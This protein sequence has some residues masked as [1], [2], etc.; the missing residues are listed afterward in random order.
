MT[1]DVHDVFVSYNSKDSVTAKKLSESLKR[2][3]IKVWTDQ[4]LIPG[5]PFIEGI[6]Q[7]ITNTKSAIVLIGDS[8]F[9]P[10][11]RPEISGLLI[12]FVET[13]LPL[14][15]VFLPNS[16]AKPGDL[17]VFLRG[18]STVDFRNGFQQAEF[19]RLVWAVTGEKPASSSAAVF[20]DIRVGHS[21][22][23]NLT[24]SVLIPLAFGVLGALL[25]LAYLFTAQS[26]GL[27]FT[28]VILVMLII[29]MAFVSVDR[30]RRF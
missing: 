1:Q 10:W 26:D 23:S 24:P 4:N 11:Q 7:V 22:L 9:G 12:Q 13:G 27:K 18:F 5:R 17:P 29:L 21:I 16:D 30:R 19:D 15:P 28:C 8:G 2:R 14:I 3:G 20:E 25:C 6:E